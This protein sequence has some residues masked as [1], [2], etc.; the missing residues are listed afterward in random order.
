MIGEK[1]C[2]AVIYLVESVITYLYFEYVYSP[3]KRLPLVVT[4]FTVSYLVLYLISWF[5]NAQLN[6]FSFCIANFFILIFCYECN[7]LSGI[8]Q[9]AFLTLTIASTEILTNLIITSILGDYIAYTHNLAAL[10]SLSVISKI[11]YLFVTFLASRLLKP[12]KYT[13]NEPSSLILL[14]SMPL[15]STFILIV[16]GYIW[17][18]GHINSTSEILTAICALSLLIINVIVLAIYNRIQALDAENM[19]LQIGKLKDEA[20]TEYYQMLQE[21]YENQRVLIHDIKNHL[22]TINSLANDGKSNDIVSYISQLNSLPELQSRGRMCSDPILNMILLRYSSICSEKEIDF[23]CDI[24]VD[25][26]S[27]M[28]AASITALFGNLLSNA[29]EAAEKSEKKFIELSAVRQQS[30]SI[31]SLVNS[32]IS[33]PSRDSSGNLKTTKDAS[34]GHGYGMKSIYRIVKKYGGTST[35]YFDEKE[36][37]FHHVIH[38][39]VVG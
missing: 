26:V 29:V 10:I 33:A 37:Q 11:L 13:A 5:S 9:A 15:L 27:F 34:K 14:G 4:S 19:M 18:S 17:M 12:Q 20:D 7:L 30:I 32:C 22:G 36:K 16:F 31:I 23:G 35:I 21:Q 39:P 8:F 1:T 25:S 2:Y 3:R 38:F 28:D 24:R 6:I